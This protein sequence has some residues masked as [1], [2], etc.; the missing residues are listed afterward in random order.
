MGRTFTLKGDAA[1]AFLGFSSKTSTKPADP[2]QKRLDDIA[3]SIHVHVQNGA[4]KKARAL[5]KAIEVA[6]AA[7]KASD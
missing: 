6:A 2:E 3:L 5:I 4:M 1:A 7:K